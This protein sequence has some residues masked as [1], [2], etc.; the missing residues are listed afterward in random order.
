[1]SETIQ[2]QQ[3]FPGPLLSSID[4]WAAENHFTRTAAVNY[5]CGK[6]LEGIAV[7]RLRAENAEL[8]KKVVALAMEEVPPYKQFK[9]LD[10]KCLL[11][12]LKNNAFACSSCPWPK[13]YGSNDQLKDGG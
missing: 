12:S 8:R 13:I 9:T 1:M 10:Q 7:E 5:M 4:A 6:F 3:R 2:V 11:C